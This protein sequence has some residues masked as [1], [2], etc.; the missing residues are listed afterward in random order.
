M[1]YQ[2]SELV[3]MPLPEV[4]SMKTEFFVPYETISD[5]EIDYFYELAEITVWT[6][7]MFTLSTLDL[8][9]FMQYV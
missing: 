4:L 6:C 8:F 3:R 1:L 7:L 5:E 9:A 2:T